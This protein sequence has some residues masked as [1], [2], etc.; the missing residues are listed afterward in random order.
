VRSDRRGAALLEVVAAVAILA[1][2]GISWLALLGAHAE[3]MGTTRAR[4]RE[5]ADEERLLAAHALLTR[6]EL[7][8]RI[9]MHLVG[10]YRLSVQRPERELF[11]IAVGRGAESA[12]EDLVT[13][14]FREA[15]GG[16]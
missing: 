4:E 9:G 15:P 13:V 14:V 7:E 5:L 10:P 12:P 2:A 6:A 8:Q 16:P 1:T 3:A 11:R